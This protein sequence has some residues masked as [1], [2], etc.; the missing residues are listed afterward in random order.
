MTNC[1]F[2]ITILPCALMKR[3]EHN[4]NSELC[5]RSLLT[6]RLRLIFYLCFR[7]KCYNQHKHE[8]SAL[9]STSLP[10]DKADYC[11]NRFAKNSKQKPI[12][13]IPLSCHTILQRITSFFFPFHRW[14]WGQGSVR[15]VHDR[16]CIQLRFR[17][18]WK[19]HSECWKRIPTYGPWFHWTGFLKEC[20]VYDNV[21]A[22]MA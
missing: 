14:I 6:L 20:K 2:C 11:R 9:R 22:A 13:T 16:C 17:Y 3:P 5:I 12:L 19:F 15:Q 8:T 4:R 10:T 18:T 7:P 1:L 21:S